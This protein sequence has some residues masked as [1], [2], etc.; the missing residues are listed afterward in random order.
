MSRRFGARTSRWGV[1]ER[2]WTVKDGAQVSDY[3]RQM[4]EEHRF[5]GKL[6]L[7]LTQSE[8][9]QTEVAR[10][11]RIESGTISRYLSGKYA[12]S[13]KNSITLMRYFKQSMDWFCDMDDSRGDDMDRNLRI[14]YAS[15][16]DEQKEMLLE[17]AYGLVFYNM[18]TNE[19]RHMGKYDPAAAA[20]DVADLSDG[21]DI[22]KAARTGG[23]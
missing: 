3:T 14:I 9:T 22:G 1:A 20:A 10:D 7:L 5:A 4:N 11:C 12:P 6:R 23:D 17:V 8:K 18:R 21:F 16:T 13:L 19:S 15:L 2:E